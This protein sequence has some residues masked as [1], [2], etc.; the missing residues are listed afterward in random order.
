MAIWSDSPHLT[1]PKETSIPN[2]YATG[3]GSRPTSSRVKID[4]TA[5]K[6]PHTLGRDVPGSLK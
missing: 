1:P 6:D 4:T 5:P 3:S 2:N